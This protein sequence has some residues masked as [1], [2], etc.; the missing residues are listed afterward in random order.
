MVPLLFP[1]LAFIA[2]ILASPYLDP[3]P[4]WWCL[5]LALLLALARRGCVLIPV[6][7]LGAGL[8]SL[9]PPAPPNPG[10]DPVRLVGRL[11]EQPEWRGL[12]VYLDLRLETVDGRL[13]RGRA[14]LTEF[15]EDPELL[16]LF[17]A[18]DLGSGDRVEILVKLHRPVVYRD[19]GVFDFRRHLERQGIYWTGVI[20]NP[21]LITVL[22]KGWHGPD[23]F[24][25]WI[26]ARLGQPFES[27]RGIHGLVM[28][29]VLGRKYDLTA[30]TE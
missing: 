1:L 17:H 12:G 29:M 3:Q 19:P 4:V 24:Q 18:L 5:P 30:T 9:E 16:G 21:R 25:N 20:R 10:S 2:G 7:L 23:R 15:L 8:R 22:K 14:R 6:F 13:Y 26:E 27:D 11:L 28:G